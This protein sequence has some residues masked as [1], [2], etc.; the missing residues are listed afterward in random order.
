M[1]GDIAEVM[2]VVDDVDIGKTA[3]IAAPFVAD[4]QVDIETHAG[5]ETGPIGI[6]TFGADHRDRAVQ[7]CG[8]CSVK[9]GAEF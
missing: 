6:K 1:H 5:L 4:A 9:Q 8:P 3:K 7:A 2:F